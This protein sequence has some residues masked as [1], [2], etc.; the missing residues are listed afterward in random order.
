MDK[1]DFGIC[2]CP[3]KQTNVLFIDKK[4]ID[5]TTK[6]LLSLKLFIN[7]FFAWFDKTIY[8]FVK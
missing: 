3:D 6:I 7:Y 8:N 1:T 4:T 5:N 2:I